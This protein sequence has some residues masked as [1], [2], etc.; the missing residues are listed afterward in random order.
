MPES[1][2][3]A[4]AHAPS[5]IIAAVT[6]IARSIQHPLPR[7]GDLP[8]LFDLLLQTP[9]ALTGPTERCQGRREGAGFGGVHHEPP[10]PGQGE[11]PTP[12]SGL[13]AKLPSG[14][15][16][17]PKRVSAPGDDQHTD[18]DAEDRPCL[19]VAIGPLEFRDER[20]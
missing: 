4:V 5:E 20:R 8:F 3:F 15:H 7:I 6:T 17:L 18:R 10:H 12:S 9:A 16:P 2:E 14:L 1:S 19:D 13:L 11:K